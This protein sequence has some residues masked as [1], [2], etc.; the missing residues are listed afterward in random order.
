MQLLEPAGIIADAQSRILWGAIIFAAIIAAIMIGAF[1]WVTVHYRDGAPERYIPNWHAGHKLMLVSWGV[2]LAAITVISVM[3]WVTIHALDPSYAISSKQRPI[4]IQVIAERWKWLF[5]YPNDH[6]AAV[7]ELQIPVG[8]PITFQLTA[9][10]PMASFWVPRL[11]GQIYAMTGMTTTLHLR[12]D[13]PGTYAGTSA[14][15][16]G[17]DFAGMEFT[18]KA[19]SMDQYNQWKEKGWQFK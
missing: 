5:V 4:T 9:D 19:V 18:V 11:G 1:F 8:V 14:E 16:S 7:N 3:V 17:G 10:A 13:Q 6:L 2:P 15:I 12:A